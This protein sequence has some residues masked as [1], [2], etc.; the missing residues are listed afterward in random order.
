VNQ[1]LGDG[2]MALFGAPVALED[3]PRR[4]VLAALRIR[5]ALEAL[6]GEVR[7]ARGIDF[8][9]RIGIHTGLVVVGRI[10]DDLRMDYTAV[11]DTTNLAARLQQVARPG[12]IVISETTRRLVAG[13]FELQ[14]LGAVEVKG[15]SQ[16]VHAFE[17]VRE[18]P[19]SGRIDVFAESGLTSLVGRERELATL[20]GA[21][22]A[23]RSGHGQVAFLVGEAG[24]GKS[25][26]LYEF[27]SQLSG[28]PHSWFEGRCAS[29][30][31]TTAFQS[32]ADGLRRSFGIED[33]DDDAAALAK[34]ENAEETLGGELR[35]T[36]PFL[37]HVLSLPVRD[38]AVA[39]MDAVTRRSETARAL[40][41]RF[42]RAAEQQPMVLVIEDLHWIDPASEQILSFL[43][44]SVPTTRALLVFTHR[45]G[46]AHPFGD[47]SYHLRVALQSLSEDEMAAMAQCVLENAT[48]PEVLR[49]LIAQK[50]EG[51]PL[52][53]EEVAKSLLEQGVLEVNEGRAA[54]TRELDE[55][56]VPDSIHGVLMSRID[57]LADEPK[58]AIQVASV[59][60]REFALRLLERI[61][62]ASAGLQPIINE[63]RALELIY[64]KASHPELA[65]MFKHAL[66]HD[67]AYE[68]VLVQR[69]RAL[70]RIVGA[71]IEELY[72]D[73]L[74]EHYEALAHHFSSG[75]DWERALLYHE[76]ASEKAVD[77]YANHSAIEHCRQALE[78]AERLGKGVSDDRRRALE[79][80]LAEAFYCVSD[81]RASGEAYLRAADL[82]S[83]G[84]RRAR[85]LAEASNSFL[86]GHLYDETLQ[87]A[88]A[89][90]T[91]ARSHGSRA[92]EVTALVSLGL[93]AGAVEGRFREIVEQ[94]KAV[95]HLS[96][97]CGD[98]G[99]QVRTLAQ[100]ALWTEMLG[101][102]RRAVD[103]CER[104]LTIGRA[105]RVTQDVIIPQWCLGL[106]LCGLGQ[107]GRALAT[108]RGA[109][110]LSDRIGDRN[111]KARLLNTL[112]WCFA[113][114]GCHAEASRF[115]QQATVLAREM[116][117][118]ELVA[119]APEIHANAAINLACNQ[120]ALGDAD[121][122]QELLEPIAA[123]L[124]R[125]GDPWQRWRYS[126]HLID[127][128]ARLALV[129][130]EPEQAFELTG[131][132]LDAARRHL[133]AKIE[134]RAL[135]LRARALVTM[136]RRNEADEALGAALQLARRIAYPP[137]VWRSLSL[138]AE[139]ARRSGEKGRAERHARE[140]RG[141]VE[142]LSPS[143][144]EP[145]LQREFRGLGQQL[146]VD[147]LG[148]YR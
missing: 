102:F 91:L 143:L 92:A 97:T 114:F 29:F 117:D 11:G 126:M 24:I 31:R 12:A 4:A 89:A 23:A 93:Y 73:R 27:R 142:K 21:F 121:G 57:R 110:D 9:M 130:G 88:A 6:H 101:D 108:F 139:L 79:E 15:K 5:E 144:P 58:R 120:I 115:N 38:E 37:H 65:F 80:R 132:E 127:A 74:A 87:S 59:I 71:A 10:G 3:A 16:P 82:C 133:S 135:E 131:R 76:R 69:R 36:L 116:V 33:R 2:V 111:I 128:F 61:S 34:L 25:R 145:E 35:W 146:A 1:F 54:L 136:D 119:G 84:V 40:Q 48:L 95:L 72:R 78:I 96:E 7:S 118:L 106:S 70:H 52:F 18:R 129:R 112:G 17:V 20:R 90:L 140:A 42:L 86:W 109:L 124:G 100:V 83:D 43:A 105:T 46:Y 55:I 81:N 28:E 51:N 125:P 45:P 49:A 141:V 60:G 44:E 56:S 19:V 22:E 77:A 67:V 63:L 47:R 30:G 123:D 148:A 62:E 13:F 75:E 53:V 137:V 107:Y 50:A 26:L 14:D 134:A 64:E 99:A 103:L 85:N 68:S 138:R 98:T 104:A 113:E 8:R 122:A 94:S 39:A 32:L 41:A 66:T 147:P